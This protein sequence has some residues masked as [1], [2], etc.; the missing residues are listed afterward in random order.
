MSKFF[1]I[2][3]LILCCTSLSR[4]SDIKSSLKQR[5]PAIDTLLLNQKVVEGADGFVK[6]HKDSKVSLSQKEQD[7]LLE[8]NKDR[9]TLFSEMAERDSTI[10]DLNMAGGKFARQ[11]IASYKKGVLR[12]NPANQL[13]YDHWPPEIKSTEDL[14]TEFFERLDSSELTLKQ[15]VESNDK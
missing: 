6:A 3:C 8:E 11:Y 12:E 10:K 15:W 5:R 9:K 4:A 7:L 14:I 1:T 2:L 13:V